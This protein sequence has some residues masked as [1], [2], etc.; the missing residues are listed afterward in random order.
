MFSN[1]MIFVTFHGTLRRGIRKIKEKSCSANLEIL[2]VVEGYGGAELGTSGGLV[3]PEPVV[4][5]RRGFGVPELDV[6][7][8]SRSG[9]VGVDLVEW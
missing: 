3:V 8:R 5:L 4:E 7:L 2:E 9:G 1:L 6:E